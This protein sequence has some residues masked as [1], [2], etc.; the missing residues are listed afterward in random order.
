MGLI[1][2]GCALGFGCHQ[3]PGTRPPAEEQ[4]SETKSSEV[5]LTPTQVRDAQIETAPVAIQDVD[6]TILASG[7]VT[8]DDQ[9]VSHVFSPISGRVHAINATLGQKVTVGAPL[10]TIESPD[11]GIA[12]SDR[13]K[14]M[15]DLVAA[16]HDF[17]RQ[18]ELYTAHAASQRDY[19]QAEDNFRKAKAEMERARQKTRLFQADTGSVDAVTGTY[20]V[21]SRIDGEVIMRFVNPG[22]EIQGQ[23]SGGNPFEMFTIGDLKKVWVMADVF[24]QDFNRVRVGNDVEVK[25]VSYPKR[26]FNGKVDWVSGAL[27]PATRTAKV[28]CT[29]DNEDRALRPE[30]YATVYISVEQQKALAIPRSAV[31]R[32]GTQTVVFVE[33]GEAPDHRIRFERIPVTV[34]EGEGSKWLPVSHGLELGDKLVVS[35]AILLSSRM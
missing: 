19:E 30:M 25:V 34:D 6:D 35:G 23:Y 2:T 20:I 31:L 3:A 21:R 32:L 12:S 27:D 22:M 28:R 4:E 33:K 5:L 16:E 10:A 13:S 26:R 24:E 29:L 18:K 14:A 17:K 1:L 15:A 7:K 11:V 8:F 9:L